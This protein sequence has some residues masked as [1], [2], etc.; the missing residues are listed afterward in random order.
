M[1]TTAPTSRTGKPLRHAATA[2]LAALALGAPRA[3]LAEEVSVRIRWLQPEGVEAVGWVA[4]IGTETGVYLQEIDLGTVEPNSSGRR[5]AYLA[6]DSMTSYVVA[7]SAY[8]AAGESPLSNEIA[9]AAAEVCDPQACDDGN[10][11]TSD[12]CEGSACTNV[13]LDDGT[14]CLDGDAF[15]QCVA[16]ACQPAAC[17]ADEDCFA[18][19]DC[20]EPACVEGIGCMAVLQPNGTPCDDGLAWTKKDRCE[21][22]MC[23]GKKRKG[24]R[25]KRRPSAS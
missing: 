19:T 23:I 20:A 4:H 5:K 11:C 3:A 12:A 1:E 14:T 6:L 25:G 13:A 24:L 22:G 15:G 16:G 21:A 2:L 18:A 10:P 17:I 8:N 7:L 9:I